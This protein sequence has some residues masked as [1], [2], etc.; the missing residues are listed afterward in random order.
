M[1]L[2]MGICHPNSPLPGLLGAFGSSPEHVWIGGN[3]SHQ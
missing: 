1:N 2:K 3:Q